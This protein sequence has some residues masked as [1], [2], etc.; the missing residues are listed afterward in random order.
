MT[1]ITH[2]LTYISALLLAVFPHAHQ[3]LVK[4]AQSQE[5]KASSTHITLVPSFTIT[6]VATV[7]PTFGRDRYHRNHEPVID[8]IGPDKKHF[9]ATKSSCDSFNAAWRK[10]SI[11][12]FPTNPWGSAQKIGDHTYTLKY[13]PDTHS[14]TPLETLQ[15]LNNYR[16]RMGKSSLT[17]DMNLGR[18]AQSRADYF[19]SKKS[20]D[21][22]AG[23]MDY[24]Q[25]QDGFS[26]LG[27]SNLGENSAYAGPLT[28][29][30]LIEWIFA[31]DEEHNANQLSTKWTSVGIG[32]NNLGVDIIF[33][34]GK[35]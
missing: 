8:C 29:P 4:A 16:N 19:A 20:L 7:S 33:G 34:G 21:G 23:F 9:F 35:H 13:T 24:I 26:K 32:I 31:G 2:L 12:T 11:T 17:W 1:V 6:P 14:A 27:F 3:T 18:Y 15:A 25:N 5:V 10:V 28:G 22:H 30:H